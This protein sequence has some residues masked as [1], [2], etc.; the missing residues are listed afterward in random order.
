MN[1]IIIGVSIAIIISIYFF[2]DYNKKERVQEQIK[3][4]KQKRLANVVQKC[5]DNLSILKGKYNRATSIAW[6]DDD[7]LEG[8][9][10]DALRYKR[11]CPNYKDEFRK[12]INDCIDKLN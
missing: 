7:M 2:A 6:D 4:E 9:Q 3:I 12:I 10:S 1:K 11:I 8:I 5:K